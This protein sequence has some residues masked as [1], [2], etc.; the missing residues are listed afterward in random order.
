MAKT[1]GNKKNSSQ[2]SKD[3]VKKPVLASMDDATFFKRL[4]IIVGSVVALAVVIIFVFLVFIQPNLKYGEVRAFYSE[5]I[6][7]GVEGF[8]N[9]LGTAIGG[10]SDYNTVLNQMNEDGANN[11][12]EN[13]L[14]NQKTIMYSD[15]DEL[16]NSFPI[17]FTALNDAENLA[18]IKGSDE[19]SDALKNA[20]DAL[21]KYQSLVLT[22]R[23]ALMTENSECVISR[24]KEAS[25][26][27]DTQ[28]A[29]SECRQ[30]ILAMSEGQE[31]SMTSSTTS[32][33][34][35]WISLLDSLDTAASNLDG[36]AAEAAVAKWTEARETYL[37]NVG[38][39]IASAKS[40]AD[41]ALKRLADLI[42][43]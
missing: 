9:G 33:Y 15:F 22:S 7:P 19:L 28:V 40:E 5:N 41:A 4:A 36:N 31:D 37:K 3:V 35:A 11:A 17:L 20:Q 32:Y 38:G 21:A 42:N 14:A 23:N 6:K 1:N 26:V 12:I 10:I 30:Y 25:T 34:K 39:E 29:I 13:E 18:A 8:D 2:T 16:S 43:G 24:F 27:L